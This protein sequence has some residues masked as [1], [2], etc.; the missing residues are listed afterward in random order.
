VRRI[1]MIGVIAMPLSYLALSACNGDLRQYLAVFLLQ[2]IV[3]ATT[4]SA[5]YTRLVAG[6]FQ[7]MRGLALAIAASGPAVVGALAAPLLSDFIAAHGWRAGYQ[8]LAAFSFVLGCVAIALI[9]RDLCT[10]PKTVARRQA[11][12]DYPRIARSSAFW[13][14]AGG[15]FLCNLPTTLFTHQLQL[16]LFENG[17]SGADA[18]R[19]IS[20][21]AMGILVGRFGCGVA[22]DRLPTHLVTG[23][24]MGLP[25]IG[26]LLIGSSF[27]ATFAIA[28]A[29]F[30]AGFSQGAEGDVL[31]YVVVRYF[32][33]EIYGSVLGLLTALLS[34]S[35]ACGALLLSATLKI[36]NSF[37]L[38]VFMGAF[39]TVFGA[40]LLF[41]LGRTAAARM[42]QAIAATRSLQSEAA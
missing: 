16:L 2:M 21:F 34:A 31:A 38:F 5:V 23:T 15:M 35:S 12:Q 20:A 39:A 33:I 30:M 32:G 1:A 7:R 42:A 11:S 26:M 28:F 18:A 41:L 13:L 37:T 19:M 25:G 29:V 17:V 24:C 36:T 22:L 4:G 27:D 3:G 40:G 10:E 14:L 6:A 8:V 9:P